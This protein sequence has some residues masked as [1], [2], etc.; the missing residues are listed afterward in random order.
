MP[1]TIY[2]QHSISVVIGDQQ[3]SCPAR[4][5]YY[6]LLRFLRARNYELDK[7]MKMWLD[8]L[9]WRKEYE[10]DTILDSF[11]FH[12]REQFLMAYPQGYHKRDKLVSSRGSA[13]SQQ[14]QAGTAA[15]TL[16]NQICQNSGM[17]R[18]QLAQ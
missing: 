7:A 14:V 5:D 6:T 8:T 1:H 9:E 4:T 16:Q 11:M 13:V 10:V 18:L 2:I 3:L 17:Q 15:D 12:E